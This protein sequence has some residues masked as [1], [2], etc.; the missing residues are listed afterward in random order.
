MNLTLLICFSVKVRVKFYQK[1]LWPWRVHDRNLGS[2]VP[3]RKHS[4]LSTKKMCYP[5]S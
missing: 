3:S 5:S 2:I 1:R 4:L